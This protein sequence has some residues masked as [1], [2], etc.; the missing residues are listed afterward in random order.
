MAAERNG[1]PK[2]KEKAARAEGSSNMMAATHRVIRHALWPETPYITPLSRAVARL[3]VSTTN[4]ING[5]GNCPGNW[6]TGVIPLAPAFDAKLKGGR[7]RA[8]ASSA[9]P[10]M[11][12]ATT[13]TM[14]SQRNVLIAL[15]P[16]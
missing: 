6:P 9:P 5:E 14:T 16:Y 10:T 3:T 1:G 2:T 7:K 12:P 11:A 8:K 15:L 4:I 13:L